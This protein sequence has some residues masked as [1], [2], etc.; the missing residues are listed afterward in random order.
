MPADGAQEH[1]PAGTW[2]R[3]E[4]EPGLC[5]PFS[6]SCFPGRLSLSVNVFL[7]DHAESSRL[8]CS[9]VLAKFQQLPCR[10]FG[11]TLLSSW[12]LC[13]LHTWSLLFILVGW[14]V[15]LEKMRSE[16]CFQKCYSNRLTLQVKL[17]QGCLLSVTRICSGGGCFLPLHVFEIRSYSW[18]YCG[19]LV[20]SFNWRTHQ[21]DCHH[22]KTEQWFWGKYWIWGVAEELSC[23][24]CRGGG[25]W[26]TLWL[27]MTPW[28]GFVVRWGLASSPT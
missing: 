10:A 9:F 18:S 19:L 4:A 26:E 27:S 25:S 7:W 3:A 15:S 6:S 5:C 8:S 20:H 21:G 14:F 16:L 13:E 11:I 2:R 1:A 22:K 12:Q 24:V 17:L 28:W 23:S